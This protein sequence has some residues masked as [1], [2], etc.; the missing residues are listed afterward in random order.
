MDQE[1][2]ARTRSPGDYYLERVSPA[3]PSTVPGAHQ[4]DDT[5]SKAAAAAQTVKDTATE[6]AVTVARTAKQE[7]GAVVDEARGQARRLASEVRDQVRQRVRGQND[8]LVE[9]LHGYADELGEMADGADSPVRAVAGELAQRGH[10]AADYLANRGP[11]GVL[12][13]VQDFARR[14]PAVFLAGALAAGFLVGR[15]GKGVVKAQSDEATTGI[16]PVTPAAAPS[17]GSVPPPATP[18]TVAAAGEYV[19]TTQVPPSPVPPAPS[20]AAASAWTE[21][22]LPGA[23]EP[24]M[25]RAGMGDPDPY[26]SELYPDSDPYAGGE[27]R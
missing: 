7:A 21:P 11:E 22:P 5:G 23:A 2:Y 1:T 8:V 6:E 14:R 24:P 27:R 20:A 12:R 15:L 13:E 3:A 18:D 4:A 26:G 25:P 9:R 17:F 16:S 10:R 19:S